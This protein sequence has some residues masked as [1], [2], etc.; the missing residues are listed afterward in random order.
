MQAEVVGDWQVLRYFETHFV[1]T[2][3][4]P[5]Q[6]SEPVEVVRRWYNVKKGGRPVVWS[7]RLSMSWYSRRFCL[8][9]AL[10]LRDEGSAYRYGYYVGTTYRIDLEPGGIIPGSR[11]HKD[12]KRDGMR[13]E[14][15]LRRLDIQAYE[16]PIFFMTPHL[17]TLFK[18]KKFAL[19]SSYFRLGTEIL[20]R[21][22]PS[23]LVALRRGYKIQDAGIWHDYIDDLRELGYDTRSPRWIC[24]DHLRFEHS[25]MSDRLHEQRMRNFREKE[26]KQILKDSKDYEKKVSPFL[27]VH[28]DG[29]GVR[30]AI[31]PTVADVR[32]EGA[33]MHHCVFENKYYNV[34]TSLLF[35]A[36]DKNTGKRAETIEFDLKTGKVLQSRAA[37]NKMSKHH[38]EILQ[39][40]SGASPLILDRAKKILPS[41]F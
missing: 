19:A 20:E 36:R 21:D 9:S 16:G 34:A 41:K 3:G 40:M 26:A 25:R 39:L 17:V 38:E 5:V 11:W 22:W 32:E 37:C 4:S 13:G 23:I 18:R 14:G 29:V 31:I 8:D 6:V 24:P 10:D 7:R 33:K 1:C 2:Y 15:T 30:I 28:I 35:S 27:D 12:L